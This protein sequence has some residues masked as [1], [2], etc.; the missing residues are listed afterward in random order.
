MLKL[1]RGFNFAKQQLLMTG[2]F[3][4]KA[5]GNI[6]LL[7]VLGVLVKLPSFFHAGGSIVKN[8]DGLVYQRLISF[9]DTIT[10]NSAMA[11]SALAFALNMLIAYLLLQFINAQRLMIKPNYLAG[12]AY[13]LITSFMPAF[14][15]FSAVLIA[16]LLLLLSVV[17]LFRSYNIKLDKNNIFNAGLLIGI[18]SLFFLPAMLFVI[19]AFLALAILRPFKLPEWVVLI[20]GVTSPYYFFAAWLFLNDHFKLPEYFYHLFFIAS[21]VHYTLWHAGA[22]F[23]LLAPLLAGI[24]YMQANASKMMAHIRKGWYLFL[25][26]LVVSI[27]IALFDIEKTSENWVILLVPISAFHGYG[28]LNADVK[29]YPKI[30]FWVTIL[31]IVACQLFSGL[32]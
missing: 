12:M 26:Y 8:S 24:Y 3:K 11:Y 15:R 5:P 29:I 17:L 18:A 13:M 9:L 6:I 30:S 22:L 2:I 20:L 32:W 1:T 10:G 19:W 4:Q 25:W 28:Y 16:S 23:L 21:K 14:N 27:L 7:F 31:F